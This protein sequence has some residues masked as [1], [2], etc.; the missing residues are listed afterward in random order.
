[1]TL[2]NVDVELP[3]AIVTMRKH[4]ELGDNGRA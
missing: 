2:T 1:M 3:A 4:G